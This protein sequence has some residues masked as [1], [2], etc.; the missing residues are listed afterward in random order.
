MA[1]LAA[2]RRGLFRQPGQ[3]VTA[4][5]AAAA[6][7]LT[8]GGTLTPRERDVLELLGE[9]LSNRDIA[10]RLRLAERT[11]KAHVGNV[12]AKLGVTS[13]TQ[14]ALAARDS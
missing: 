11:V 14:A 13:R 5:R 1:Q 9:G 10:A 3:A 6:A 2:V 7:A 12:L 8:A 4:A